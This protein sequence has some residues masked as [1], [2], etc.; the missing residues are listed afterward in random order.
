M[1]YLPAAF[2]GLLC[3]LPGA[4]LAQ[5]IQRFEQ[6]Y[7]DV[8][9][10]TLDLTLYG[11]DSAA[12]ASAA[13]AALAE[14]KRLDAIFSSRNNNSEVTR[15]NRERLINGA[16]P[17]LLEII[18]LCTKW[19]GLAQQRFSCKLGR[20]INAW[21]QAEQ[22]Q[23]LPDRIQLRML[24]TTIAAAPAPTF[25]RGSSTITLPE[26][27]ELEFSGIAIGYIIDHAF[28][29]LRKA[30]PDA[31]GI[32]V[33]IGG[34]A[35][36]WGQPPLSDGTGWRVS[37]ASP[38]T[39]GEVIATLSTINGRAITS[40]HAH[41]FRTING[42]RY[43][44]VL[45]PTTGWP[46]QNDIGLVTV[47][48]SAVDT[49]AATTAMA[50][51][52]VAQAVAWAS[53]VPD[54]DVLALDAAGNQATSD[55]WKDFVAEAI[56]DDSNSVLSLN[57][58]LPTIV[59]QGP[60]SRPYVAIWVTDAQQ[61]LRKNLLLLGEDQRWARENTRW[62][63]QVGRANPELIDGTARPTRAPGEYRLTWD[64][65]D[66]DGELLPAGDYV[67]HVE[68]AR[69]DGGHNYQALPFT[70]GATQTLELPGEGEIG[71]LHL[72]LK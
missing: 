12:L 16:S 1:S 32:K 10:T 44:D 56:V 15:L 66:E 58:T 60:Y 45:D 40:R 7:D 8:L 17:E 26:P 9:G 64:G 70:L 62:W 13:N 59:S 38:M 34:D 47:A 67:L 68:A 11:P 25:Y 52:N 5:D 65:H 42:K 24:A 37:I 46:V 39:S 63:R 49:D 69:Q 71:R 35:L 50:L 23:M 6:H 41:R 57:Y 54:L 53:A 20:V 33:D 19:E 29:L 22:T 14:I 43:S 4:L 72:E 27:V 18:E 48:R 30:V 61:A 28:Y 36:Y 31:T 2:L 21:N 51:Q 3:L 55:A